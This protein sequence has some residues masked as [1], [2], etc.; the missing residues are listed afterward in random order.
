MCPAAHWFARSTPLT[1]RMRGSH[2]YGDFTITGNVMKI[3]T[4][5]VVPL[6]SYQTR[7]DECMGS[8]LAGFKRCG[9]SSGRPLATK[10]GQLAYWSTVALIFGWAA[11][12]RFRL[13]LD[14]VALSNYL[15]PAL[16]KL[17][18]PE[19]ARYTSAAPLSIRDSCIFY[20][21]SLE[22]FAR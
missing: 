9:K 14:P 1:T 16:R 11:W 20:C 7:Q 15:L 8:D 17:T 22:I 18:G 12:L 10:I 5:M 2:C 19:L 4:T 3:I 6:H 13:L 21:G